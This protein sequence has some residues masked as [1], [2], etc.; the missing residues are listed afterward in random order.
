MPALTFCYRNRIDTIRAQY[1]IKRLWNIDPND[2]EYSYFFDYVAT[3]VNASISSLEAFQKFASD[4]RFENI[5]MSIIAKDVHPNVNSIVFGFDSNLNPQISEVMT[6]KGICYSV[7]A[8]LETNMLGT[9]WV[10]GENCR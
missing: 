4:K 2:A 5:D 9:K 3:V 10:E 7:N 8:V 6:E 1:L